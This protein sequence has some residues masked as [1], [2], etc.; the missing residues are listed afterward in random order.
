MNSKQIIK[1][2]EEQVVTLKGHN[3]QLLERIDQLLAQIGQLYQTI[4]SL[5]EALG[6]ALNS[7]R[8]L[9]KIAFPSSEAVK[10]KKTIYGQ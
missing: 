6:K 5:E 8:A 7:K 1:V 3:M 10:E 4:N 9:A 2:L